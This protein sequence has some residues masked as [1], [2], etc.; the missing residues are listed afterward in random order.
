MAF[1]AGAAGAAAVLE[2]QPRHTVNSASWPSWS[3]SLSDNGLLW[4]W[5]G[6]SHSQDFK[7][8]GL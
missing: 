8:T 5:G 7:E 3:S 2:F 6:H 4:V 1:S